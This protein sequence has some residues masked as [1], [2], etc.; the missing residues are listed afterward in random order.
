MDSQKVPIC[1][2]EPFA[3]VTLSKTTGL[4]LWLRIDLN[5]ALKRPLGV[6]PN[7]Y[8]AGFLSSFIGNIQCHRG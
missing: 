8:N 7:L 3:P 1:H 2:P 5:V 6:P 4:D